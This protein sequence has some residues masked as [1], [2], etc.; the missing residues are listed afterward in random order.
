MPPSLFEIGLSDLTK[1][2]GAKA[3]PGMTGP[4]STLSI[5]EKELLFVDGRS[6]FTTSFSEEECDFENGA[7]IEDNLW[8]TRNLHYDEV[9]KRTAKCSSYLDSLFKI[10]YRR[11]NRLFDR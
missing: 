7:K 1:S 6:N 2:G 5:K 4:T 8:N 10:L 3:H 11:G 9:N